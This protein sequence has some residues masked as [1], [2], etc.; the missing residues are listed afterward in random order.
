MPTAA[1]VIIGNEILSGKYADEN[2]PWLIGRCREIGLDVIR[3]T[4][5]SDDLKHIADEV[6][7]SSSLADH[8][9]TT[10]GIGPTHDDMTMQ[11]IADAFGVELVRH[12]VL[13]RLI[14]ERMGKGANSDALSMADVPKGTELWND[15]GL[16]FPVVT[17]RNVVIFPGVP[18]FLKS[19]FTAIQH[20]FGGVLVQSRRFR[21]LER[22]T[23]IAARLRAAQEQWPM[24]EVGSYPRYET[25]PPSVVVTMDGRDEKSLDACES[26][27]RAQFADSLP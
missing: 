20:R 12:P 16:R 8:V 17:C 13:E 25:E 5:V 4:V 7:R 18:K 14:Q 11:G 9:F 3:L 24:V 21:T 27:L 15:P 1:V 19:K 6:S 23:S 26:W 2:G 10:G 22:E